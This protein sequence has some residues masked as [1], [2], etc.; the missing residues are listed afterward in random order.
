[1]LTIEAQRTSTGSFHANIYT[2]INTNLNHFC[3]DCERIVPLIPM[4]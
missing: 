4:K 3:T 1:M 2:P